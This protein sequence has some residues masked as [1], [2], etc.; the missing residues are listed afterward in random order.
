MKCSQSYS[1]LEN[2][3]LYQDLFAEQNVDLSHFGILWKIIFLFSSGALSSFI[4]LQW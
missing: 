2:C 4:G 1:A 3:L